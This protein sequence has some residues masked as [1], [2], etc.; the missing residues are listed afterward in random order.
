MSSPR[1]VGIGARWLAGAVGLAAIAYGM[2]V[3]R[4]F[5]RYGNPKRATGEERDQ[6]LDRFMPAYDV[7]E[8]HHLRV[9]APART[10]LSV[11]RDMPL[12][13]SPVVRALLKGRELI[14][15]AASSQQ[16]HPRALPE[17]VQSLGWGVLAEVPG[18]EVVFG[19]VT[20][21]W[22]ANVTFRALPPDQFVAFDE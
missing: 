9:I 16:P 15:G 22:E 14:L 5:Q 21:P 6:L 10:T 4:A 17:E 8:R 7:V 11:A 19:A 20:K 18:R 13:D 2:N 3:G 12:R 1:R